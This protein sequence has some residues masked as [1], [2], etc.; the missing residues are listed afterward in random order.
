MK[1]TKGEWK[2]LGNDGDSVYPLWISSGGRRICDVGDIS[3]NKDQDINED[4]SNAHLIAAAPELLGS[5]IDLIYGAGLND[6]TYLT[7]MDIITKAKG[8]IQ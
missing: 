8:G 5:L 6:L 2:F 7:A 1:H 3:I 4:K